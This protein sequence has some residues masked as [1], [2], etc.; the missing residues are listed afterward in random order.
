MKTRQSIEQ[1]LMALPNLAL[2]PDDDKVQVSDNGELVPL[3]CRY[4]GKWKLYWSDGNNWYIHNTE[5]DTPT[6]AIQKV[7]DYCVEQGWIKE[8]E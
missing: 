1:M 2:D 6:E 4:G 3:L 8:E 7:Y 5:C